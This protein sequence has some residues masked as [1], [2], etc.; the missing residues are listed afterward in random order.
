MKRPV[1]GAPRWQRQPD[2]GDDRAQVSN[3]GV[4]PLHSP[5]RGFLLPLLPRPGHRGQPP[6]P[7]GGHYGSHRAQSRARSQGPTRGVIRTPAALAR[8][9]RADRRY[10]P[11]A[12]AKA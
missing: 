1:G 5:R 2:N 3:Y 8:R 10:H 11:P 9:V 12:T 4:M 6:P 7:L